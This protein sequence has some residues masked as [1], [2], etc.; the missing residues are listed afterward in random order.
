MI[1]MSITFLG[2]KWNADN[3]IKN[4][5]TDDYD[6]GI[7]DQGF[8]VD[9]AT[10]AYMDAERLSRKLKT[11]KIYNATRGG[12]LEVYERIDLDTLFKNLNK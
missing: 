3:T 11:F 4:H 6:K 1:L 12:K 9:E 8:Q 7:V 10:E 2:I 5:F